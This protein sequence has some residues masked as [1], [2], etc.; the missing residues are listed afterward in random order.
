MRPAF[1]GIVRA[2]DRLKISVDEGILKMKNI[3]E[4]M[5][6]TMRK[7]KLLFFSLILATLAVGVVIGTVINRSVKADR[8]GLNPGAAAIAIPSP[9]QLSSE[10]S[11]IA[12]MVEPAVVNINTESTIKEQSR[13]RR[14]APFGGEP[15]EPFD[16]FERFFG[17]PLDGPGREMK[18]KALGSGFIVDKGGYIVTNFH[19]VDKADKINVSLASGDE[20]PAKVIGKDER[21][22]LAVIKIDAKKELSQANLGN[23]DSMTQGDWVLAIGSPFGLEQTVTAGIISATGRNNIGDPLQRFLQTD[24]AINQ[25]NSGGPLVNMAGEVIGVNT[26]IFTPSGASAGIGFALPSNTAAN[27]YNQ[28]VKTGKVTRGAIGIEMQPSISLKALKALGSPDGKG[29]LVSRVKPADGPA[30]KAGLK[31]GDIIREI[32]GKKV[33]DSSELSSLVADLSPGKSVTVNYLRDGKE[34]ST[35]LTI[36]DRGKLIPDTGTE[37]AG[38]SEGEAGQIKLGLSVQTL[39][40][41]QAREFEVQTDEGVIIT[42]VAQNSIAEDAGLQ[43]GDVILEVNRTPIRTPQDLR[44]LTTKLKSGADV[45]FLVKRMERSGEVRPLYFATTIP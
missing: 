31:Q 30:A 33:S 40:S 14:R 7:R 4:R 34:Q 9:S 11:K 10:F 43:R 5:I 3:L 23:S 24:A 41:Q 21:T 12:K 18:T 35:K 27:V 8:P 42:N 15:Q 13:T 38:E 29:V 28:L 26:A 17:G 19:V 2:F 39:T 20:Y 45:V 44:N 22:D 6:E 25:G 32:D 1:F 36:E 16:F 37:P